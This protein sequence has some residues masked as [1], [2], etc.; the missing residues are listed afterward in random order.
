[1]IPMN[2]WTHVG[3][4]F[5]V[6]TQTWRLFIGAAV[7]PFVLAGSYTPQSL[8]TVSTCIGSTLNTTT[9]TKHGSFNGR[10]DEVRIWNTA[11]TQNEIKAY[12]FD[13][14]L[15]NNSSGLVAY[16]R[17]NTGS[18][19][20]AINLCTN[21][22]GI[23]GTL[24][25]GPAWVTSPVLFADNALS[26][27]GTNDFVTIADDNTLDI[28]SAITLEAWA[29]ATKN[30]GI[31]NVINKSSNSSNSGYIFPR[32]DDGWASVV[33]YLH[34]GG[35]QTLSAAY[36]SL[37]AWHHLAATYD[38]ATM[39]LYIDGALAASRAQTG[40]ITINANPLTLGNQTGFAEY[41]GGSADEF[42]VWNIARTQTQIQN[43]MN[44]ELDP[45]SQT[46]LVSYYT[47]NEQ[48]FVQAGH[49]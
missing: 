12:L 13:K 6:A 3:A 10:I 47:V 23:D 35:W 28:T 49:C 43:S 27:D 48:G 34:V 44:S 41:F 18:G 11:R 46:G 42:R 24:T 36:P 32:T 4:S 39:K 37:N 7:E 21:T 29:Y 5:D 45:T 22:T 8:S 9:A 26:F 2:T 40:T 31:Q 30:S 20:T 1:M 15:S 25:N 19:S 14:N 17:M 33:F 38:G 16:Y